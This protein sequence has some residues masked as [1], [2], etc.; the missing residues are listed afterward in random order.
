M[1]N[2]FS[3]VLFFSITDNGEERKK[4]T[5][6]NLYGSIIIIIVILNCVKN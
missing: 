5:N 2:F 1:N 6:A 3:Y 4:V